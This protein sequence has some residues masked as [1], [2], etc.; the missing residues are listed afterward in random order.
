M[1]NKI[2]K[3]ISIELPNMD[4]NQLENSTLSRIPNIYQLLEQKNI[5]E[6]ELEKYIY[7]PNT[8]KKSLEIRENLKK[9]NQDITETL[10]NPKF[11]LNTQ[12]ILSDYKLFIITVFF[13]R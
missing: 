4:A 10:W 2:E 5:L 11:W 7:E 13:M 6:T 8:D 1:K 12:Q 9:L 3:Y